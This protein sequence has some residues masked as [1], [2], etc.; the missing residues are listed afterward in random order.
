MNTEY[1]FKDIFINFREEYLKLTKKLKMLEEMIEVDRDVLK[2]CSAILTIEKNPT[3][4]FFFV[5]YNKRMKSAL[6]IEKNI[7]LYLSYIGNFLSTDNLV[8]PESF[9]IVKLEEFLKLVNELF[10]LTFVKLLDLDEKE[11]KFKGKTYNLLIRP[12]SL[13]Q[14]VIDT[15]DTYS[16]KYYPNKDIVSLYCENDQENEAIV[17]K[18]FDVS[19]DAQLF[20]AEE[21]SIITRGEKKIEFKTEY[22]EGFGIY[23]VVSDKD[24]IIIKKLIS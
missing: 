16:F 17:K 24:K 22:S 21:M 6:K 13:T 3:L 20:N 7:N 4:N 5:E 14:E 11:T 23:K 18:I 8:K 19:Y 12:D 10:D 9:K 2:K 1:K 15:E